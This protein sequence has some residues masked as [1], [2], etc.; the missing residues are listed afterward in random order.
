MHP[1]VS[2]GDVV[3]A[4][5]HA[6][7][8][9]SLQADFDGD[10][11]ADLA[12]SADDELL[13]GV[14]H[15]LY[16]SSGGA[17][18]TGDQLWHQDSPGVL[19]AA[20][21]GDAFGS[22]LAAGDFDDDGYADLAI[23]APLEDVG[24][25]S[26][27]G[28]VNV[29]YGSAS[30]LSASGNQLWNQDSTGIQ[31]VAEANDRFGVRLASG[32]FDGDGH[33]DLAI[34]VAYEHLSA[35]GDEGIV[36]VIY[37][38][39]SGLSA[40]G[41]QVWDQDTAGILGVAEAGDQ[42]GSALAA[43][44]FD[45]DGRD[46][47]AIGVYGEDLAADLVDAGQVHVLYGSGGGLSA[48]GNQTWHQD[49][50]GVPG[51][52]EPNDDFGRSLAV[53][54]F[55]GDGFDDLAIGAPHEDLGLATGAGALNVIHGSSS[56]LGSAGAQAWH[57]NSPGIQGVAESSDRFAWAL[58]AGDFD[59]DGY[60]DLAVGVPGEG[61]P[62]A[63][64]GAGM[65]HVLPGSAGGISASGDQLWHQDSAGVDGAAENNDGF[66][67]ALSVGD[68]DGDGRDDLAIGVP[69]E[70]VGSLVDAGAVN[71]LYATGTA[72]QLWHQDSPGVLGVA[73][74]DELFGREL[75]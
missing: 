60:D 25:Q 18:A 73:D 5:S 3:Q 55:D 20:E 37:G 36:Q 53:G 63:P 65:L 30:G 33:D 12:I 38:S 7:S 61:L 29:L 46:D 41:N 45:G 58:A 28:S 40:A 10:G 48:S 19:G 17:T 32:D 15:V 62:G 75:R 59:A 71:I 34:G 24:A 51:V 31:G 52:A 16:G 70:D 4:S 39:A 69:F 13:G 2:D 35:G 74:D 64:I 9:A 67:W 68:F 47:L 57:Q 6:A 72:N 56:G 54:D 21:P 44:D 42:F 26:N 27:A 23:G 14:V 66:G 49:S 50:P 1:D 43:G 11:Y 8:S 22:V